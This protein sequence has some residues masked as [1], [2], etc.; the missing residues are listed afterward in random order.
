MGFPYTI[1]SEYLAYV[2][3]GLTTKAK[4]HQR[5]D[6]SLEN[7][8]MLGLNVP[9]VKEGLLPSQVLQLVCI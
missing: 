5:E 2:M 6:S 3:Q 4:S 8:K 7:L 9:L 1:I